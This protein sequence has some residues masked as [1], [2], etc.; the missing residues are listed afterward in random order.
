MK[1]IQSVL[2]S[3]LFTSVFFLPLQSVFAVDVP[4]AKDPSGRGTLMMTRSISIIPVSVTLDD[5]ELGILFSSPVG[6][7]QIS[8]VDA[9]GSIVY[10]EVVDTN[11]TH[12]TVIETG[13]FDSGRFTIKISYGSTNLIGTI[14][15]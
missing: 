3:I 4:L 1:K 12:E 2:V 14:Q 13:G 6:V 8:I 11:S 7:A 5:T 15:L 10:Q 9:T